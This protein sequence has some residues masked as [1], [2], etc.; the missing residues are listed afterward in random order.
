MTLEVAMVTIAQYKE[1]PSFKFGLEKMGQIS[2]KNGYRVALAHFWVRYLKLEIEEDP[3]TT[4]LEGTQT[5]PRGR[6][7]GDRKAMA[8][9]PYFRE[10]NEQPWVSSLTTIKVAIMVLNWGSYPRVTDRMAILREAIEL[11][12]NPVRANLIGNRLEVVSLSLWKV[13]RL[14]C[15]LPC[16]SDGEKPMTHALTSSGLYH[17]LLCFSSAEMTTYPEVAIEANLRC[18]TGSAVT[19]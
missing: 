7:G 15:T 10:P 14:H 13:S 5:L 1:T 12:V 8:A 11:L 2:Y 3:Y 9:A 16:F 19:I 18:P 4:L 6:S 17:A